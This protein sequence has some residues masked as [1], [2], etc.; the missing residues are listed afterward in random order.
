MS[1]T[2]PALSNPVLIMAGGTGGHIFP[3]LAVAS[4]LKTKNIDVAWMGAEGAMEIKLVPQR[5]LTLHILKVQAVRGKGMLRKLFA[6]LMLLRAIW[7][8][9]RVFRD[10][11]PRAAVSFGGFAAGPGGVAAFLTRTPLIVHEQNRAPGMTNRVLA[12]IAKRVLCGFSNTFVERGAEWV[13]NPVRAE[14]TAI[15]SPQS[16]FAHVHSPL[17]LLVLGGSQGA[18]SLNASVP[19]VIRS[20][21]HTLDVKHQ[22]GEKM[23]DAT[24]AAYQSANVQAEVLPFIADMAAAYAWADIVIARAGALT[25]AELCAAGLPNILVPFPGAVDDHQAKNADWLKENNAGDWLR[26]DAGMADGLRA[27]LMVLIDDAEKRMQ[28][29]NA[30]RSLARADAAEKIAQIVLQEARV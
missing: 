18:M 11:K 16:R 30:A 3:G 25:I 13:G 9:W 22:C 24:V 7:Q 20:L 12:R 26:Q 21:G 15:D 14:I 19:Q 2:N 6:P 5:G 1:G 29:A 23:L 8:A 27:R 17:R 28:Q 4:A 10:I